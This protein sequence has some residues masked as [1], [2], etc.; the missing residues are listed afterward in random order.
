MESLVKQKMFFSDL[1][2]F[3]SNRSQNGEGCV[4]QKPVYE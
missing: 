1:S 4:L 3:A 2:Q